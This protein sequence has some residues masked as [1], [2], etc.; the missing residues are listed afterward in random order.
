MSLLLLLVVV[1]DPGAHARKKNSGASSAKVGGRSVGELILEATKHQE[2]GVQ[3]A[4]SGR[5]AES[6][7]E[8]QACADLLE[9]LEA[10]KALRG[11][12]IS[13]IGNVHTLM[14]NI[15]KG[16]KSW[17]IA[18]K[19]NPTLIDAHQNI[20]KANADQGRNAEALKHAQTALKLHPTNVNFLVSVGDSCKAMRNFTC[21]KNSYHRALEL[22]PDDYVATFSLAVAHRDLMELNEAIPLFEK[23]GKINP[24]QAATI[25]AL[26]V[27]R[28]DT[29]L[30]GVPDYSDPSFTETAGN[31]FIKTAK[32]GPP[33]RQSPIHP[34]LVAYYLDDPQL[35]K[36]VVASH[37]T[38]A[39]R[40]AAVYVGR[41]SID[42]CQYLYFC[43]SKASTF[44]LILLARRSRAVRQIHSPARHERVLPTKLVQTCL[45]Y[46]YK[47]TNTDTSRHAPSDRSTNQPDTDAKVGK[48]FALD[49]LQPVLLPSQRLRVAYLTADIHD[50]P[51][52]LL[53]HGMFLPQKTGGRI[54]THFTCVTGTEAQILTRCC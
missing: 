27:V 5:V 13:M 11:Q 19:L 16:V 9:G 18:V 38:M 26:A 4:N 46:T 3:L 51:T 48:Y 43:T 33:E 34:L 15:N 47:S 32:N 39:E 10:G 8:F 22:E 36:L 6:M 37:A 35:L 40:E 17:Q 28:G 50:H 31:I 12:V 24:G 42:R 45:L 29:C 23:A 44:V 53:I 25:N 1:V 21:A 20:I 30:W 54:G 7:A 52:A 14:G 49:N 41:G 2:F